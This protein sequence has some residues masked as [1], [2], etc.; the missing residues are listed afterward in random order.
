VVINEIQ[1]KPEEEGTAGEFIELHNAGEFPVNISGWRMEDAITYTIPDGTEI[2][3]G[4][5][6]VIA[7]D[8]ETML[9]EYGVT[10][11]GPWSGNLSSKGEVIILRDA[12]GVL[13]DRV[14]YGVGFPW[15]SGSDGGGASMELIHPGLE[16]SLAGSW[17]ASGALLE[18]GEPGGETVNRPTPG[19][20]NSVYTA[21]D[22]VPPHIESVAHTPQA[23]RSAQAVIITAKITDPEGVGQ[24]SLSYQLVD[25][26]SYIRLTDPEYVSEWVSV[27]MTPVGGDVWTATLPG[28]MQTHRR[29]V[30]YRI[31]VQDHAGHAQTVPYPDDESP[32]FA[33]FINDGVPAWSGALR[34]SQTALQ[35]Y[36]STLLESIPVYTL[37]ANDDDVINSQYNMAHDGI[38]CT[39]TFVYDDRVYDHIE[40]RNRG[41]A[42]TYVS[43]KNK[44]RFYFNRAQRLRAKDTLGRP[45]KETWKHL[46]SNACSSPWAPINRG[47]AGVDEALP[48]RA[49]QLAGM[50]APHTHYYHFRI[51]RGEVE[52]PA[53]GSPVNNSIGN[54]DGQYAG[55]FWGLYLAIEPIRGNFL[56]ERD[57]PDGNIYEIENNEGDKKEQAVGQAIDASDWRAFRNAILDGSPSE[58]WWRENMD[59]DAYYSFHAINRLTGNMDLRGGN[60]HYFYHRSSDDRWV[61]IPWDLDMMFI[62]QTHHQTVIEDQS[63]PGVI[64]AHKAILQHPALALEFRNRGREILDLLASDATDGGG[65][66]G[67]LLRDLSA[68]IHTA[69]Q[70]LTWAN[71]DAAMWNLHPRTPG[72]DG[73]AFG[74]YNHRGNFFKSP[75]DD[76]R[77]GGT[78]TGWLRSPSFRGTAAPEDIFNRFR[79][80]MTDSWPGGA[81]NPNNGNQLGYGYQAL[82]AEIRDEAIPATPSLDYSGDAGFPAD[83]L[84]FEASS[85]NDPQG[86]GSFAARQW[87]LAEISRHS[88]YELEALWSTTTESAD[89]TF[90]VFPA[91]AAI[92]GRTYR[93]RVRQQDDTGRWSHWS[94]PVTFL[95]GAEQSSLVHYWNFNQDS[96]SQQL[97]APKIGGGRIHTVN[98]P[99]TEIVSGTGQDFAGANAQEEDPAGSHLRVNN[100]LGATLTFH[101]PTTHHKGI[102]VRFETRR[103]GQGAGGQSWS[104]TIDGSSWI[105]LNEVDTPDGKPSVVE[106]DFRNLPETWN[107]PD[108]A[109]RVQFS[110]G[111]G[112]AAG[113]NRFDNFTVTGKLMEGA[114]LPP[115]T[116]AAL[117]KRLDVREGESLPSTALSAWFTDAE[118]DTLTYTAH[119]SLPEQ[120]A[121]T[122][123]E[124]H[125]ELAGLQRGEALL[126]LTASDDTHAP[127]E[128]TVRVLIHPSP[129]MLASGDLTFTAW[130]PDQPEH[131]YPP[132]MLFLQS[133]GNDSLLDTPLDRAYFIPHEDY[134]P[135]DEDFIGWPYKASARTRINGLG[136]DGISFINTGRGRDLGGALMALDTRGT[137]AVHISF[138][139]GTVK[140]N[141][142]PYA[143]RLQ[144]R[145]GTQGEFSDVLDAE[146]QAVEYVR[147]AT[148]GHIREFADL[149]LPS[150]LL[151]RPY[152]QLLWRYH[153]NEAGSGARAELSLD[154]IQ[155]SAH[156]ATYSYHEWRLLQFTDPDSVTDD[157]V[158]GPAAVQGPFELPNL[159][160]YALGISLNEPLPPQIAYITPEG[161]FRFRYNPEKSDILW[162]VKTSANL[163]DW[164]TTLFDS[165]ADQPLIP[166]ED[167]W[168]SLLVPGSSDLR[169]FVRLELHLVESP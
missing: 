10:A 46:S 73:V 163:V 49:F 23:P 88:A 108:F 135:D 59:M 162:Q 38:R 101:I 102:V 112:G 62:S 2:P 127:V 37:I 32:N 125:L 149:E 89:A 82:L 67:Q 80:Y 153:Q 20:Q 69:G 142:R 136:E 107:N 36:P 35:T 48:F 167:G 86:E 75:Y 83:G 143:L 159:H 72:T 140:P 54:A 24:V 155:V 5:Y 132:S 169:Q 16:N 40:Y 123:D 144:Y 93:A 3:A 14:H 134:S 77:L 158:S 145:M 66:V 81:W 50:A 121:F 6:V 26:G 161:E 39:G 34:P 44:W 165:R 9:L 45:Y 98:G 128:A 1:F 119:L 87:R 90:L 92:P 96:T 120:A 166:D 151:G 105:P 133:E 103:S 146:G 51:V 110:Q 30:R 74:Q 147:H 111:E 76:S 122:L 41:E 70:S 4:G 116:T 47:A 157:S 63:I 33:Y 154:D 99:S 126:T 43:G 25:P 12:G 130:S 29:L 68:P 117:P 113:N 31:R 65:Q 156:T 85:F 129:F 11:R 79:D 148:A 22:Q 58:N 18:S 114:N 168:V 106:L 95:V 53:A 61:P 118:G 21:V 138:T 52:T 13:I 84:R 60:N 8:P 57:L 55:D 27:P 97:L 7:E 109:V 28:E 15:P 56:D 115:T 104:Y 131:S 42:S 152:V 139:A 19:S 71:A 164:N 100:P 64:H 124:G 17:R 94:A 78:W 137:T 160:R 141:L 150:Y 91:S